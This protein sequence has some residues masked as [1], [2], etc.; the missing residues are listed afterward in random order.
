MTKLQR[1]IRKK[2][3]RKLPA[4]LGVKGKE[5]E[6]VWRKKEGK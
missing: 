4:I 6:K 2:Y 5:Q 1:K 3:S